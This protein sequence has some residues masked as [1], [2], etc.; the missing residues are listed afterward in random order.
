[1]T[2][3][4]NARL[5]AWDRWAGIP[6]VA[7]LGVLPRRARPTHV[8]RLGFLR[9]AAIGDTLLLRAVLKDT[10]SQLPDAD[11]ALVTGEDNA[12]AGALVASGVARHVVIRAQ[13]PAVAVRRL[14]AEAFDVLMDTGAW[15]RLDALLTALS[16]ARFR[17][18]FRTVG[19]GRHFAYDAAVSHAPDRHEYENFRA[20]VRLAGIESTSL[21]TLADVPL[22]SVPNPAAKPY[23]V[24]HPWSGGFRGQLKEWPLDRWASLGAALGSLGTIVVTGAAANVA[25]SA[26]LARQLAGRGVSAV[27]VAGALP[28]APLA[29]L[30]RESAAVVSVNTGVMHLAAMVGAPTVSLEGPTPPVRWGP[31][32]PRTAS[33]CS[34]L[35]GCGYLDL[36]FEYDGHRTDCMLGIEVER[37]A[38]AV[39]SLIGP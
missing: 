38:A 4:A 1:M 31:I 26:A 29:S 17:V 2:A 25:S 21:P 20:L 34:T 12:E 15:P 32:G 35:P 28:L 14:R 18:G 8:R 16:G 6:A 22:P 5:R 39:H 24:F 11:L 37:V 19:Q 10:R 33:V 7:L 27:S 13:S 36:G 9:T 23:V 3:R 30:L